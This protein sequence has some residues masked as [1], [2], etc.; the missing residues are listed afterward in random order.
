MKNSTSTE[1]V[2]HE[3]SRV[4]VVYDTQTG[5]ILHVHQVVTWS[6]AKSPTEQENELPRSKL[7]GIQPPLAY[8]HGP[9]SLAGWMLV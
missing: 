4:C 7:R 9:A 1:S 6:R 3:S 2:E 8:S 5:A